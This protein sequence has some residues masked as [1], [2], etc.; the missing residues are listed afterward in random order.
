MGL[1]GALFIAISI[2]LREGT[3]FDIVVGFGHG[4]AAVALY[5]WLAGFLRERNKPEE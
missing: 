1:F 4:S 2:P 3:A 5:N